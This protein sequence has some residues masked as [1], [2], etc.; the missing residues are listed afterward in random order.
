[1]KKKQ[2][3][4][5]LK[6]NL[7]HNAHLLSAYAVAAIF[8]TLFVYLYAASF[9][10]LKKFGWHFFTTAAW[11]PVHE[12]FGSVTPLYGTLVS[13]VIA[14]LLALPLSFGMAYVLTQLIRG[15]ARQILRILIELLAG[16][17]SI[18]YGMWGLLVLAK[19]FADYIQPFLT[20][21]LGDFAIIGPFFQGPPTGINL[22]MA[23]IILGV[24][25]LPFITSVMQDAFAIVP[26]DLI[27]AAYATGATTWEVVWQVILPYTRYAVFGGVMLGLG[28]ALGETMA[29]TFVIGNAGLFSKSLLMP[30]A[31]LSSVLA[32]E[33]AE[34][35][36]E[37]YISSLITLGL[38]LFVLTFV[39][40]AL[41]KLI[42][43][44]L[45]RREGLDA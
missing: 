20:N 13:S 6:D 43:L 21:T 15:K 39:V 37:L 18:I 22:L 35:N 14:V 36:G 11:D 30:G 38:I 3:S 5:H 34:A 45:K 32:N 8:S 27:E 28:R 19:G 44:H 31:T 29:V 33:F 24:M 4:R 2:F 25:I 40:L 12:I 23:G 16:I 17:P 10:A 42:L 1:M 26:K 41:S 9:P 7:F